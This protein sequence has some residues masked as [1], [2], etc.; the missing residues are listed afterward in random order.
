MPLVRGR[1]VDEQG[2]PAAGA[3]IMIVSG[4]QPVPDI[5]LLA[6]AA[7]CFTLALPCPG[8]WTLL[9]AS[10]SASTRAMLDV[11][12]KGAQPLIALAGA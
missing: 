4:P 2:Q 11:G 12:P 6:D 9:A 5:A 10:D 7:G 3:R 8:S 1:V